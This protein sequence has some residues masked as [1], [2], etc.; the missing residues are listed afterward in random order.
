MRWIEK[1]TS[2]R[3]VVMGC[4][5][6]ATLAAG[7]VIGMALTASKAEAQPNRTFSSDAALM[8]HFVKPAQASAFE[9]VM[10]RIDEALDAT[11]RNQARG[12]KV[13]R[14]DQDLTGQ[15]NAMYVWVIDPVAAGGN[16]AAAAILAEAFPEEVQQLYETYNAAYTDGQTKQVSYNLDLIRD[17]GN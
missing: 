14:A 2:R 1:L 4:A 6:I 5:L 16:Y 13:Y 8:L 10:Q 9:Q 3:Q 12:W 11:N 7:V 17:F 15:G